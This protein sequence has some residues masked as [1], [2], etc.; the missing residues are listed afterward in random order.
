MALYEN[1]VPVN[2][3]AQLGRLFM[4]EGGVD[5]VT[6]ASSSSVDHFYSLFNPVQRRQ[7]LRRL[8]TAVIG[9]VTA[10]SVKKWGGRVV[11][12]PQKYTIPDLVEAIGKWAKRRRSTKR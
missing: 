4:K 1:Q 11:V 3:R 8:P 6:F 9:P 7:W 10:A 2:S 5:L 12:Q